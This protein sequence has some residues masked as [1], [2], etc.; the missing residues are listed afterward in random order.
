VVGAIRSF[1]SQYLNYMDWIGAIATVIASITYSR[2]EKRYVSQMV[3]V[4][5]MVLCV[6]VVFVANVILPERDMDFSRAL[7]SLIIYDAALYTGICDLLRFG[8]AARLTK[9]RGE[10]WV[11][12]L[13]YIYLTL[14]SLGVAGS[15]NKLDLAGGQYTRLD[16]LGPL[17]VATAIVIRLVKTRAEIDGWNKT[18]T[19][20]EAKV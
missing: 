17:V 3:L 7:S 1:F 10:K 9:A 5:L 4:W 8:L 12:E 14:G 13:D 16:L 18:P 20:V 11:K 19:A 15:M 6:L 2:Y